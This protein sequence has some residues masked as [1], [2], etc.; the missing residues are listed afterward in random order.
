MK[1][2]KDKKEEP[3]LLD[4]RD[5]FNWKWSQA[6]AI[7]LVVGQA[8]GQNCFHPVLGRGSDDAL[9]MA[10]TVVEDLLDDILEAVDAMETRLRD[11]TDNE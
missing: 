7:V 5:Q 2:V 4:Y 1:I 8:G 11:A 9:T 6:K 10:M 3:S